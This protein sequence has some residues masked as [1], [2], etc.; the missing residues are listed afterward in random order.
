MTF[1]EYDWT[2]NVYRPRFGKS[3][4]SVDGHRY[5]DSLEQAKQVLARRK[6]RLGRKTDTRTW[7]V[8]IDAD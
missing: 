5:F 6:L 4:I 2:Y 3:F 7:A 1:L 8:E